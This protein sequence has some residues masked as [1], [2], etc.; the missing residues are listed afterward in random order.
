MAASVIP[1]RGKKSFQPE[2]VDWQLSEDFSVDQIP[3]SGFA[4]AEFVNI[5]AYTI[6]SEM[7]PS[8]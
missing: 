6:R 1:G 2:K 4:L 5:L 3:T 8:S 7:K